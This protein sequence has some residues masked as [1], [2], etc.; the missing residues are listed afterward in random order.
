VERGPRPTAR[1]EHEALRHPAS[2]PPQEPPGE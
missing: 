1:G 2:R